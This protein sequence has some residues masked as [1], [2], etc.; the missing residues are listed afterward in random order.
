M[1]RKK[2]AAKK[3]KKKAAQQSST[4][5]VAC[6]ARP[7]TLLQPAPYLHPGRLSEITI[8]VG[9]TPQLLEVRVARRELRPGE[10]GVRGEQKVTDLWLWFWFE[11][12][13][14]KCQSVTA[15]RNPRVQLSR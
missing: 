2:R 10:D 14:R 12:T 7:S 3:T 11:V 9:A 8:F 4:E 1:N 13:C 6:S 15:Q 5:L